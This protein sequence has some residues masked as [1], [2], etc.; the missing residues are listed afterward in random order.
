METQSS[1]VMNIHIG[2]P[3]PSMNSGHRH[4]GAK[5]NG[6][7]RLYTHVCKYLQTHICT[8]CNNNT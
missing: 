3:V 1:G 5:V 4:I 8:P 7:S 2:G 6:I